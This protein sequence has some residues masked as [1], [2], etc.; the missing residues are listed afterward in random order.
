[1]TELEPHRTLTAADVEAISEATVTR[2][3]AEMT[4]QFYDDLGR[5]FWKTAKAAVFALLL[6]LAAWGANIS[7]VDVEKFHK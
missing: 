4:K 3:R 6:G 5:G 2:L 1:M 7:V